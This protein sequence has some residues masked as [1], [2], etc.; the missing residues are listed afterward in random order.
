MKKLLFTAIFGATI[1]TGC[2]QQPKT[3]K[4]T[5]TVKTEKVTKNFSEAIET[6]HKKVVF[7]AKEAIQFNAVINFGGNEILNADITVS[8]S[9]DIAKITYKNGDEIYVDKQDIFVSD[10]LKE[11]PGVRFH[12]YTWN[13]FFLF[14][15]KL[16]DNGTKWD[17]NHT[18]EEANNNL[19]TA[20]L[21][22]EA[23]TGDA[24]DD[25]YV[26]YKN[27]ESDL[28]EHVAYI[29]TAGKTK[30][31]AEADPHAIKYTD[32]KEIE[33]ISIAT[34]WDFYGWNSKDGLTDKIGN[35]KITNIKFVE[36]F[37]D[38]FSIPKNYIKK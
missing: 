37:R 32:Y 12:A 11:N 25:W 33:G 30:E 23:N 1:I 20:K 36:G 34:N 13:Y 21:S 9:S 8:T 18:T 15:Y 6:A 31:A 5:E 17:F 10:G 19:K 3:E 28:L 38:G 27:N 35:A 26:V 29:V 4:T 14:P 22:F 16:N 24:P 2:K 7:L